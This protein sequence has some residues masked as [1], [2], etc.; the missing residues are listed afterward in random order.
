M[1]NIKADAK[2]RPLFRSVQRTG[3][4]TNYAICEL[5]KRRLKDVRPLERLPPLG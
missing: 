2:D 4:L 1:E 3:Q 5:V